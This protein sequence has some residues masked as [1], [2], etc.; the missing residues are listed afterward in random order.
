MGFSSSIKRAIDII[1]LDE[2]AIDAVSKDKDAWKMGLVIVAIGAILS[3]LATYITTKIAVTAFKAFIPKLPFLEGALGASNVVSVSSVIWSPIGG[4]IGILIWVGIIWIFSKMFKGGASYVQLLSAMSLAG[5][6]SWLGI[7]N[8][9]PFLGS[10]VAFAAGIWSIVVT[11]IIVRKVNAIST[12]K[13]IAVVLI[14]YLMIIV[15]AMIFAAIAAA[16]IGAGLLGAL[17]K[18]I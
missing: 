15:I 6:L 3:A 12:G 1:K 8:I 11:V 4:I 16:F 13:A 7:L 17:G 9:I 2:K 18:G 10:L 5:L 14:P